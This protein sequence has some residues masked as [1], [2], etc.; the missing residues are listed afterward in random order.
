MR[1]RL[2][3]L[4]GAVL[5]C[6]FVWLAM[7][8]P[9]I[10]H[11]RHGEDTYDCLAPYDTALNGAD[12]IPGG[13]PDPVNDDTVAASCREAG[14]ER[15]RLAAAAG[16]A[17]VV[18]LLGAAGTGIAGHRRTRHAGRDRRAGRV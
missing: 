11:G 3:A 18:V 17:G 16:I 2:L 13:E 6:I 8:N 12:N 14:R 1:P 10:D 5:L 4:A 7:D 9:S 15:F